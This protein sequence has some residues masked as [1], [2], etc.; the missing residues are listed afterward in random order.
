MPLSSSSLPSFGSAGS[1]SDDIAAPSLVRLAMLSASEAPKAAGG[2]DRKS[3]PNLPSNKGERVVDINPRGGAAC[4]ALIKHIPRGDW[5]QILNTDLELTINAS[6]KQT[7]TGDRALLIL[8][9]SC[10]SS[11]QMLTPTP[12]NR[13]A[14]PAGVAGGYCLPHD[15]REARQE[16]R[17]GE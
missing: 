8:L 2:S 17:G 13:L 11:Q 5:R 16:P 10:R 14:P 12:E 6:A 9:P 1:A 7:R 4:L 15:G 3:R